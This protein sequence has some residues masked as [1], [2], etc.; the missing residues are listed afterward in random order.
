ML[1]LTPVN[2]VGDLGVI[3]VVD[4]LGAILD[5][6]LTRAKHITKITASATTIFGA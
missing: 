6:E 4:D 2:A 1:K 3:L 5:G